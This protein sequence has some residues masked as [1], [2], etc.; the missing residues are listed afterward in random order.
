MIPHAEKLVTRAQNGE[1]LNADERRHCVAFLMATA[2][3][4]NDEMSSLFQVSVRQIRDDKKHIREEKVKILKEDDIGLVIADI[5]MSYEK[6]VN[7]MEKSKTRCKLGT[8]A[9]VS[10]CK[11][12]FDCRM[13]MVEALQA[14]GYYPKN[15]GNMTHESFVY[16]ATM[17]MDGTVESVRSLN[18]DSSAEDITAEVVEV[19]VLPAPVEVGLNEG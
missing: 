16:K 10:H 13:K 12:I 7:D 5:A 9:Y 2:P 14:L 19:K 17:S 15:L 4:N 1:K 8:P 11:A 3:L 18:L 6:Q